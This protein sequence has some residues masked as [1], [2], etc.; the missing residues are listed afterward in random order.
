MKIFFVI[1]FFAF[2]A[3][4]QQ[5]EDA[6]KFACSKDAKPKVREYFEQLE[7]ETKFINECEAK[8]RKESL[9]KTGNPPVIIAGGCEWTNNGCPRN[10]VKPLYPEIAEK[11]GIFGTVTVE[12]VI[13]E[14]GN[15][16]Y[17][18]AFSEKTIFYYNAEKAA[19]ASRFSPKRYCDKIVKQ[20][21]V[22]LYHFIF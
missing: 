14:T 5:F 12:I 21:T 9:E 13:D 15:V 6:E 7:K 17:S 16:I 19:C 4:S 18:K 10:L 1:L 8:W 20:R 2:P 3:L 11:Y 22:I